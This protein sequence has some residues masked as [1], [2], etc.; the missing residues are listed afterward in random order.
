MKNGSKF[1]VLICAFSR[2]EEFIATLSS[3]ISV[4]C[5][6]IY[7]NID[8]ARDAQIIESQSK[9]IE[10]IVECRTQHPNIEFRMRRSNE[11]LGAAVSV[12]SSLDWFFQ[13]EEFG[14]ILE[15]D[16]EFEIDLFNYFEW[17]EK[18][19][20]DVD[21]VWILSGTN[22][23]SSLFNL[24]GSIQYPNYPVTWGWSTWAH[25]WREMRSEILNTSPK[26]TQFKLNP[27]SIFW[28]VGAR[29]A[30]IGYVDAW[31]IPLAESMHRLKKMSVVAPLNLV[32]NV[33]FSPMAS[34]TKDQVFPLDLAIEHGLTLEFLNRCLVQ[35]PYSTKVINKLYEKYVYKITFKNLFSGIF[36]CFD[37]IRFRNARRGTLKERVSI[38]E[39]VSFE[40]F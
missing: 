34:N 10:F 5:N 23:L 39:G 29:R 30:K 36:S 7:V 24:Y 8:G 17:G 12:I 20:R 16:L 31:D 18:I 33:G 19:F 15:D 21:D 9:M 4:G 26:S 2:S 13:H 6:R 37:S 38:L 22:F 3:V 14:V 1:P 11:N 27:S 25:K 35:E 32:R 40:E 28:Q